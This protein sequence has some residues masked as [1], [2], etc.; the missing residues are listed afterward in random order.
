MAFPSTVKAD[1]ISG[2]IGEISHDGPSRVRPGVLDSADA[3]NNVIGRAFTYA[4]TGAETMTA[5]GTGA[6]AGILVLP[7]TH[8]LYGTQ[9]DTLADSL[10]LPNGTPAEF[11]EMGFCYVSL[12]T[13]NAP[14]GA[15][16]VYNTTTG[17][18]GWVADPEAPGAGNA[19]VP[20]C[21]VD[22]HNASADTPSL[23]VIKLTN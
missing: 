20:N 15:F 23:A 10:V 19:L 18:L 7:K 9:G 16:V 2:V 11:M 21:V 14:I 8:V 1:L 3:D 5:G 22:R 4:S 6:F 13:P 17:A 12:A